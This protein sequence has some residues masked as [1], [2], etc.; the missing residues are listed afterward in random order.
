M[1]LDQVVKISILDFAA[2]EVIPFDIYIF[3][4]RNEKLIRLAN[5]GDIFQ[6]SLLFKH[7][8][9]KVSFFK[10]PTSTI[11][12]GEQTDPPTSTFAN[13]TSNELPLGF[14]SD[15]A[16]PKVDFDPPVATIE[17]VQKF[18]GL[19]DSKI[20]ENVFSK[21]NSDLE[22][23]K[24]AADQIQDPEPEIHFEG[25]PTR[26]S[27]EE[28]LRFQADSENEAEPTTKISGGK[29]LETEEISLKVKSSPKM[30]P[31]AEIRI[32]KSKD[33]TEN[34]VSDDLKFSSRASVAEQSEVE[35]TQSFSPLADSEVN[36]EA[37]EDLKI[38]RVRGS[39]VNSSNYLSAQLA[40][41]I[42]Y[43]SQVT[44][45]QF[46]MSSMKYFDEVSE[47]KIL[48]AD[49]NILFLNT[50]KKDGPEGSKTIS[51]FKDIITFLEEYFEDTKSGD[52]EK[53]IV[54]SALARTLEKLASKHS[55]NDP[56]NLIRWKGVLSHHLNIDSYSHCNRSALLAQ[57]ELKSS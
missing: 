22:L 19:E 50:L 1:K 29:N 30:E 32:Q 14:A 56:I 27:K 54:E 25:K 13:S 16:S 40:Y 9:S 6:E 53:E 57:K 26:T 7:K 8:G 55:I 17:A 11:H 45:S 37:D 12:L 31:Q 4:P 21:D 28:E 35:G 42:G 39:K 48:T 33:A 23:I 46:A 24:I 52:S 10:D 5:A 34:E 43:T 2:T 18:E 41:A 20:E 36:L 47:D 44:L 15:Q 51:D 49:K 38:K 3:L